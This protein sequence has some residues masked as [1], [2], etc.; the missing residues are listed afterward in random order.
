[1][2]LRL[3]TSC[4][5]RGGGIGISGGEGAL[6]RDPDTRLDDLDNDL[7][8][9][10]R[11]SDILLK[12][13]VRL[14]LKFLG[15]FGGGLGAMLE[16]ELVAERSLDARGSGE[17]VSSLLTETQPSIEGRDC[18]GDSTVIECTSREGLD[19]CSID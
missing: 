10:E 8:D 19:C 2:T 6:G 1:M 14:F 16:R 17:E 12:L 9:G 18:T 3:G 13:L 11:E 15:L 7:L 5:G 4:R